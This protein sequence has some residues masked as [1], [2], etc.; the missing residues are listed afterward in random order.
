MPTAVEFIKEELRQTSDVR[1]TL[2]IKLDSLPYEWPIGERRT[3][4]HHDRPRL[5]LP[6]VN[7]RGL[8][9][10]LLQRGMRLKHVTT[11]ADRIDPEQAPIYRATFYWGTPDSKR[12]TDL[13]YT[14]NAE[15][16][17]Y[18]LCELCQHDVTIFTSNDVVGFYAKPIKVA[19]QA[20]V[21]ANA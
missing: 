1:V 11:T 17:L 20:A 10:L 15:Q 19:P 5:K 12:R 21:Y 14:P 3:L 6:Q 8:P 13:A 9:R 18:R 7:L 16:V 4:I 2:R